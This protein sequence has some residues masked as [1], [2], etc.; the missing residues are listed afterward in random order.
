MPNI[1]G[2][3]VVRYF[4]KKGDSG[5]TEPPTYL[6]AEQRYVNALRNS[7][8][9]NLEEQYI[10]GTCTYTEMYTDSEE[11]EIIEKSFHVNSNDSSPVYNN[12]YKL[13]STIYKDPIVTGEDFY[14]DEDMLM[15]PD[16]PSK[17]VFGD[18]SL[19]Y[20]DLDTLY[21]VDSNI[22]DFENNTFNIRSAEFSI[23]R[24]DQLF[25]ITDNGA[26]AT[27]VLTKITSKRV[28][29]DAGIDKTV[30]KEDIQNHLVA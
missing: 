26:T 13:V 19:D 15:L 17:I 12:Y 27:P 22:F 8:I 29:R 11:N 7:G 23:L 10:L 3:D 2:T 14:F 4:R 30:F 24:R 20:P 18:G 6:G 16:D 28:I 25:F 21:G 1:Y 9:N 5:F